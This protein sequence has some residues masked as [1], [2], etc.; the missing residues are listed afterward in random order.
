METPR[1]GRLVPVFVALIVFVLFFAACLVAFFAMCALG[2]EELH[3]DSTSRPATF[4][5]SVHKKNVPCGTSFRP[6][7]VARGF[8]PAT[9]RV[10]APLR[11]RSSASSRGGFPRDT[12]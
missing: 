2:K 11:E 4:T 7:A 8:S 6:C 10:L 9:Q 5:R 12:F 3:R 1:A